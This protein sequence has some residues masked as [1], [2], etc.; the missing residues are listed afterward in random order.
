MKFN[1]ILALIILFFL[2]LLATTHFHSGFYNRVTITMGC[3]ALPGWYPW[4]IT[5]QK[6]IFQENG[7]NLN[8]IWFDDYP[9][10]IKAMLDG[11]LDVNCQTLDKTLITTAEKAKQTIVLTTNNSLGNNKIIT[12]EEIQNITDLKNKNV[13]IEIGS[14]EH[15]LLLLGLKDVG[16]SQKDIQL[17]SMSSAAAVEVFNK[18]ELDAVG[19]FSPYTSRALERPGSKELLSSENYPGVISGHL[20]V[21]RKLVDETPQIVQSLVDSWYETLHYIQVNPTES[22][23]IMAER[24][25]ISPEE[26]QNYD[27]GTQ[28]FGV[29]QNLETFEPNSDMRSLPYA[30]RQI[31]K[32]LLENGLIK[33]LPDLTKLL[34]SRFIKAY[35]QENRS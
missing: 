3:S 11:K 18:G 30:A 29:K 10:S 34:D 23:A 13:A 1:S 31:S 8:F 15:F 12:R 35:V 33:Q 17:K 4:E 32:F 26:Y 20:V 22:Y 6:N 14:I 5:Y 27:I 28:L 2:G 21:A 16:L 19:V 7:L 24:A 25:K 9:D